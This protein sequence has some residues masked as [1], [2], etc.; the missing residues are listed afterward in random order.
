MHELANLMQRICPDRDL[1]LELAAVEPILEV[2]LAHVA[3]HEVDREPTA[4]RLFAAALEQGRGHVEADDVEAARGELHRVAA[5]A[6]AEVEDLCAGRELHR[7]DHE[8][9]LG[10]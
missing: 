8:L 9:G 1:L 3:A 7:V 4:V 10:L 2:A 5:V 6:T